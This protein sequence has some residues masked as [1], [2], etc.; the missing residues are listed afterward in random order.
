MM[1]HEDPSACLF[2]PL[3]ELTPRCRALRRRE[4]LAFALRQLAFPR[5][6]YAAILREDPAL[7]GKAGGR[8]EALLYPGF[9]AIVA[10]RAAHALHAAGLP[11]LPRA[12]SLATRFLTGVDIH[13]GARIG[14]GLFIDHA[15]GVVIGETAEI[16]RDV[17]LFHQ[18]TLGGRGGGRGKRH[19]TVGD[20]AFIGAGA[21]ILGAIEIGPGARV[22]AN[23]VVLTDIPPGATAVGIPARVVRQEPRGPARADEVALALCCGRD[24]GV[25]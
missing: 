22:G 5:R 7:L 21:K 2:E 6:D 24:A 25:N 11:V 16:G 10:H 17:V 20:G 15:D 12:M 19:P 8:V 1:L 9:W 13:P 14:P 3:H 4:R 18:V 23:A